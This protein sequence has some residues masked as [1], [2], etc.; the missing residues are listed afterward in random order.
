[1]NIRI[2]NEVIENLQY[3]NYTFLNKSM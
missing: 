3:I 2:E 1:L